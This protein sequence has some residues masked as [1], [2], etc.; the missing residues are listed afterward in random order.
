MLKQ[1][2]DSQARWLYDLLHELKH[3]ASHLR[4]E[5]P[6]VIESAEISPL[7]DQYQDSDE[8]WEASEFA[9]NV[10]LF[11]RA[12]ELAQECVEMARGSV[13]QLKWAVERVAA[14]EH[15]PVDALANYLAFRLARQGLRWWGAANNLQ[16]TD[17][18]PWQAAHDLLLERVELDRLSKPDCDLLLR[19]LSEPEES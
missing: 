13:E 9:S 3:V 2:T 7:S 4:D 11:G 15:V 17:P 10:V 8:E 12:E 18:P 5:R 19:A 14:I 1:L 6:L 16:V